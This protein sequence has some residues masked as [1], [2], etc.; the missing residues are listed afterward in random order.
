MRPVAPRRAAT[1]AAAAGR[2][3]P[4]SRAA[5]L[6]FTNMKAYFTTCLFVDAGP[7]EDEK[8]SMG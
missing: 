1:A 4:R 6:A 5:E 7:E 3:T 8:P 2:A